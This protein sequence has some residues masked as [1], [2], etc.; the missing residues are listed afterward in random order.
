MEWFEGDEESL[1]EKKGHRFKRAWET[2]SLYTDAQTFTATV[3]NVLPVNPLSM[4]SAR[5]KWVIQKTGTVLFGTVGLEAIL[6]APVD[7]ERVL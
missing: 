3:S 2:P 7:M 1:S 4:E 6:A 5:I